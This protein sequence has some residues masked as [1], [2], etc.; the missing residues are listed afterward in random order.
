MTEKLHGFIAEESRFLPEED[1]TLTIYR[2]EKTNA[3][4]LRMK[5]GDPNKVFAIGFRT[6]P[7]GSTG[8]C[9][10]LEHCVLNG[11]RKYHT[12]EPF[13]DLVKSSLQTFLNAMTFP[14][15]TLY[16]VAS[17]NNADFSNL[18]DLYLDA[19]FYPKATSDPLI[20][21]QEGWR[22]ELFSSD[23]PL[24][25]QGVVYNEMRGA[26][27]S[28]E[29]QIEDQINRVLYRGTI[30]ADNSGGDPYEIPTLQ[31]EEFCRFHD[32]F[33]HP[34][35]SWTFLYG[36]VDEEQCFARLAEYFDD[37]EAAAPDSMPER[38]ARYTE[39]QRVTAPFSVGPSEHVENQAYLSCS[40]LL[41]DTGTDARQLIAHLLP[42][43]LVYSEASPL[44]QALLRELD[45]EDVYCSL[46]PLRETGFSIVAKH[47][48]PEK[49]ERFAEVVD[50]TLRQL[51][52]NG[53]DAEL[54]QATL[55]SSEFELREKGNYPTKGIVYA[56][57]ALSPWLYGQNPIDALAY[58]DDL[59][60]LKRG[61]SSAIFE[62]YIDTFLLQNPHR[63]LF[64]HTPEPGLNQRRDLELAQ[65]LAKKKATLSA[66]E[67]EA[68]IRENEA[69]RQRQNQPDSPEQKATIPVLS[70]NEV[71]RQL[72]RIPRELRS[73]PEAT[74]LLHALPT[75]GIHY[76]D[77]VF[78]ASHIGLDEAPYM[79]LLCEL[80]GMLD[81][82]KRSFAEYEKAELQATGGIQMHPRLYP[83]AKAAGGFDRRVVV[84]TKFLGETTIEQ[85]LML[86]HEQLFETDF[87][88]RAR[89]VEVLKMVR[90]Q[91]QMSL[92][93]NAHRI[94]RERALS[95]TNALSYYNERINGL[96]F[97][98][99]LQEITE[100]YTDEV[101]E[102]LL[103]VYEKLFTGARRVVNL[104]SER[105]HLE[106]LFPA[107]QH[108]LRRMPS[109]S[110][111]PS[112]I[113]FEARP[114]RE[115][116]IT[117][118]DVQYVAKANMLSSKHPFHGSLSVLSGILSTEFLYNEI[119]AKGGAYGAG[120][121]SSWTGSLCAWSY[122]D[123]GLEKTLQTYD[124]LG[125]A[126]RRLSLTEDDLNRFR[127]GA[128]GSFDQPM[129]ERQKGSFDLSSYLCG[130]EPEFYDRTLR[131]L[132]DTTEEQLRRYADALD[133]AM[134]EEHIAVIGSEASILAAKDRFDVLYRI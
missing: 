45:C 120:L 47:V 105:E 57:N 103:A 7:I 88:D 132:L 113:E 107:V 98:Q 33:Y 53:I 10:I 74:C 69:L 27:S 93:Q 43:L 101:H 106:T 24:T 99:L 52:Q 35:N 82:E 14:D 11:S 77:L 133:E 91:Y 79:A 127:I 41:H 71:P 116:F 108:A 39:T 118:V 21:R 63:V 115:A 32:T 87:S 66:G 76:L 95:S 13:M 40:W 124:A 109:Q 126:V 4:L 96:S 3:H 125:D 62:R 122:R 134:S 18:M 6:P 130:R 78:D 84:S 68:I 61:R 36:D 89:I 34:S 58:Q 112:L 9:H 92:A 16:P 15:K 54:L 85:G 30:Y 37:Y 56:V 72:P 129:T 67:Q 19:V 60:T 86:L 81:T 44:R 25:Y 128:V 97:Y 42:D 119:R 48:A 100:Q 94:A 59:D 20:F 5:N 117:S 2:H 26:M 28:A 50:E 46:L 70:K 55:N 73:E 102:K 29:S 75:A 83:N 22:Y 131:E 51:V 114:K 8:N 104:T 1:A 121:S 64:V 110:I 31:Y 111:A 23:E 80:L 65:E 17:R 123:P 90:S 49:A 12:K 38:V